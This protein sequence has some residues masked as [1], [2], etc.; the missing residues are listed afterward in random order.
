MA[1]TGLGVNISDF[2]LRTKEALRKASELRFDV[3]ELPASFGELD[4]TQLSSSG[5]RHLSHFVH[6]LCLQIG[7]LAVD[8]PGLRLTDPATAEE[9]V[10]RT[11][12]VL[13]MAADLNVHL[14]TASVFGLTHPETGD[15]SPT[16]IE[17][18][19]LIGETADVLGVIYALRPSSENSE[20]VGRLFDELRC[21]SI[22]VGLD[23]GA[24]VMHGV[25]PLAVIDRFPENIVLMHARDGTVAQPGGTG[26]ETPLG[27]GAVDLIGVIGRLESLDYRGPYIIRRTSSQQPIRDIQADRETLIRLLPPQP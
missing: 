26:H 20:R 3:V 15:P 22:G 14:V 18:L 5:R 7:A 16:A 24:M 11:R 10:A 17:A 21:P 1:R 13:E 23:P 2:H 6:G 9:L 8:I 19:R 4:P 27:E 12:R 25:N